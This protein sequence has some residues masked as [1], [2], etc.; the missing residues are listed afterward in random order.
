MALWPQLERHLNAD[1][2]DHVRVGLRINELWIVD[3]AKQLKEE[4]NSSHPV[5]FQMDG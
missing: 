5:N 4:M 3:R 2:K 1:F